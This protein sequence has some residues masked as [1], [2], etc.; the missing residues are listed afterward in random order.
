M[1]T[2]ILIVC[3][4]N[5]CRSPM[6]EGL[7]RHKVEQAGL[8]A[9]VRLD[10]AG[11]G[12]WHAGKPPDP[13][14]IAV[15]SEHGIDISDLRGRQINSHDFSVH[16]WVLCADRRNLHDLQGMAPRSAQPR[17]ALML[18]WAGLGAKSEIPD[19]Y[20]GSPAD[21]ERVYALL[22]HATDRMLARLQLPA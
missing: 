2:R 18:A 10:S 13:R 5:I 6:A 9:R 22:N 15:C 7:L 3:M 20:T 4:G 14:A 16:D 8:S 11:T 12:P 19:P 21:F 1:S 17:I